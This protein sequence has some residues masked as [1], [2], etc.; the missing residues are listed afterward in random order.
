MEIQRLREEAVRLCVAPSRYTSDADVINSP[1]ETAVVQAEWD[2]YFKRVADVLKLY[3][4]TEEENM[5][6]A[7]TSRK[8]CA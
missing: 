3:P 6:K 4:Y 2:A 5:A 7:K 8:E 1:E